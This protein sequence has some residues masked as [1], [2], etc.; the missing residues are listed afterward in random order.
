[1]SSLQASCLYEPP[2]HYHHDV[3]SLLGQQAGAAA[4][5]GVPAAAAGSSG[6][7][8]TSVIDGM[9][10]CTGV[11]AFAAGTSTPVEQCAAALE[12]AAA[13][14]GALPGLLSA[15]ALVLLDMLPQQQQAQLLQQVAGQHLGPA[16]TAHHDLLQPASGVSTTHHVAGGACSFSGSFAGPSGLSGGGAAAAGVGLTPQCP[17]MSLPVQQQPLLHHQQQQVVMVSGLSHQQQL[18]LQLPQW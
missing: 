13:A 9:L 3:L 16:V 17:Y 6:G 4:A 5:S 8:S 14:G 1:L 12:A 10:S 18:E 7:S 2:Q 11:S 15:D